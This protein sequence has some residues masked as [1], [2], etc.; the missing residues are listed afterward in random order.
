MAV[1]QRHSAGVVL[2]GSRP[3]RKRVEFRVPP[4]TA[5]S[6]VDPTGACSKKAAAALQVPAVALRVR[7]VPAPIKFDLTLNAKTA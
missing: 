1:P 6:G 5:P 3:T 4:K 7:D 2:S